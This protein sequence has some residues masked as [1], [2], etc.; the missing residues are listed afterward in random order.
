MRSRLPLPHSYT[1]TSP[2]LI[3]ETLISIEI[4]DDDPRI[5]RGYL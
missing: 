1:N 5:A 3:K 2:F 4:Y